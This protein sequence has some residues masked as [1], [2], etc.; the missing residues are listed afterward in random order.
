MVNRGKQKEIATSGAQ[1]FAQISDDMAK[2]NG[3][4]VE[5]ADVYLKVYRRRDGT[6]VMPRVQENIN[7]IVELLRQ[8]GMRL[9]GEPGSGVLWPKDDVYARVLGP[10]RLGCVRG[11]GLGITPSGRSATNAL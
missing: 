4:P 10:E 11:V 5:R 9:R 1:S 3:V 7:R 2:A 8:P 6:G